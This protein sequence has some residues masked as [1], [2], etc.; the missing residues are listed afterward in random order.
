MAAPEVRIRYK[1]KPEVSMTVRQIASW[2]RG[3]IPK[4]TMSASGGQKDQMRNIIFN[5]FDHDP[6]IDSVVMVRSLKNG[7]F[8]LIL[9][10]GQA[11]YD[12]KS[13]RSHQEDI[14]TAGRELEVSVKRL[15]Q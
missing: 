9:R 13:V 1:D 14:P 7:V 15:T 4:A 2:K 6:A 10:K 3:D 11:Y 12:V 5:A 8:F